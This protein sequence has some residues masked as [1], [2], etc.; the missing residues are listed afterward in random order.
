MIVCVQVCMCVD[1][2]PHESSLSF[3]VWT[4]GHICTSALCTHTNL[5]MCVYNSFKLMYVCV[6]VQSSILPCVCMCAC[7]CVCGGGGGLCGTVSDV[8]VGPAPHS[9]LVQT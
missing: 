5:M 8:T 3:R 9:V 6:H 2:C 1:A 4:V 7:V